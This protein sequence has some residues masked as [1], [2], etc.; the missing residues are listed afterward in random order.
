MQSFIGMDTSTGIRLVRHVVATA[1]LA[2]AAVLI[3]WQVLFTG[4][5]MGDN[6]YPQGRVSGTGVGWPAMQTTVHLHTRVVDIQPVTL[7]SGVP[8]AQQYRNIRG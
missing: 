2:A 6:R 7:P 3:A 8:N 4:P 1:I 5:A